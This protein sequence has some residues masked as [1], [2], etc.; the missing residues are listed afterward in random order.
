MANYKPSLKG[1]INSFEINYMLLTRLLADLDEVN[2]RREFF[3]NEHLSYQLTVKEKSK[4]THVI[5][6][7]QVE[8]NTS[9]ASKA[10]L[11]TFPCMLIRIYHDA[12]LAEVIES[13]HIR[14][15]KPRYDY[16]NPKMHQPDEKQQNHYFLTQWLQLCLSQ[17]QTPVKLN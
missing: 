17:G 8:I 12:R 3:I 6:F 2:Q 1:L 4:Y 14:Q 15:I 9:Q 11:L 5:E 10:K 7:R 13:Q 16:P